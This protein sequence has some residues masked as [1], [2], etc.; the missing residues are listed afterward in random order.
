MVVMG[1]LALPILGAAGVASADATPRTVVP[2][3]VGIGPDVAPRPGEPE[4]RGL[5]STDVGAADAYVVRFAPGVDPQ[6]QTTRL[7][8]LRHHGVRDL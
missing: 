7:E 6:R 1:V 3:M 2:D 8:A 5:G 4:I